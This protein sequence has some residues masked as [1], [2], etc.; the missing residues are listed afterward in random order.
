MDTL[1][2]ILFLS[3]EFGWQKLFG[4][5]ID[6]VQLDGLA[7]SKIN[8]LPFPRRVLILLEAKQ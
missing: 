4:L 2:R 1:K 7:S 8:V 3:A 5:T 6:G